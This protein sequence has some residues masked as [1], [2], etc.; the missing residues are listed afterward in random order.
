QD[1][2]MRNPDGQSRTGFNLLQVG[3]GLSAPALTGTSPASPANDN[4]PKILGNAQSGTTV[5]LF[6]NS[7]CTGPPVGTDSAA[8][9]GSPGITV[10]VGDNT[11]T[12]FYAAA[13]DGSDTSACSSTR[14]ANG[15]V[16]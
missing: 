13:T 11:T 15:S 4:S 3:S 7:S 16:T 14:A 1:V 2:T 9:F 10:P 6:T 8:N 5:N 12:T